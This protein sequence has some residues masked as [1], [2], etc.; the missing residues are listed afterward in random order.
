MTSINYNDKSYQHKDSPY[1]AFYGAFYYNPIILNNILFYI[2]FLY[3]AI[4]DILF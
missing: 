1:C 2:Y 4:N 3:L